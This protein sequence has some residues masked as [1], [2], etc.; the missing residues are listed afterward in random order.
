LDAGA[1][2]IILPHTETRQQVDE[3]INNC[4]FPPEGKRSF[5]PWSWIPGVNNETPDGVVSLLSLL[6][7]SKLIF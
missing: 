7:S 4:R 2:G 1:A 6:T 5:P 3:L